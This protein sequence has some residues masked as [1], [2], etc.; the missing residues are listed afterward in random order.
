M[1]EPKGM[2]DISLKPPMIRVATASGQITLCSKSIQH[3]KN[4]TNPK[5]DVLENAKLAAI[6]AVKKTPELVFMCHPIK[7]NQVKFVFKVG[8]DNVR[9]EVK[10]KAIDKT[11][12]EL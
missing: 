2:I 7:I 5:G 3:I 6:S 1:D 10:V 9:V 12:V 8:E 4:K 11:G